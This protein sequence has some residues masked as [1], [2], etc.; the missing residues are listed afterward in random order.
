M[1]R[2]KIIKVLQSSQD[3]LYDDQ[4]ELGD[5]NAIINK[6]ID[7]KSDKV[8]HFLNRYPHYILIIIDIDLKLENATL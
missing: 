3:S 5:L 1:I 2:D 4:E 8:T 6:V 7:D